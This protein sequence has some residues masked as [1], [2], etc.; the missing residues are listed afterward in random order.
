MH[1]WWNYKLVQTEWKIVWRFLQNLKRE[2]TFHFFKQNKNFY[3]HFLKF[4]F[5]TFELHNTVPYSKYTT[6][7]CSRICQMYVF[8]VKVQHYSFPYTFYYWSMNSSLFQNLM[9]S[10]YISSFHPLIDAILG[11]V[12]A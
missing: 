2:L 4:V 9:C 7:N 11:S 8:S 3:L 5:F 1:C 6:F 10:M 12:I